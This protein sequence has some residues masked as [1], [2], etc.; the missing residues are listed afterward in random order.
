VILRRF[1]GALGIVLVAATSA[2]AGVSLA[3]ESPAR[4]DLR[5]LNL[6]QSD[7]PGSKIV[8]QGYINYP[9]YVAIFERE[10]EGGGFQQLQ[11]SRS[12]ADVEL[13]KSEVDAKLKMKLLE[14]MFVGAGRQ[15]YIDTFRSQLEAEGYKVVSLSRLRS[16]PLNLGD[17]GIELALK[18]VVT[19]SQAG[20]MKMPFQISSVAFRVHRMLVMLRMDSVPGAT[21]PPGDVTDLANLFAS[22]VTAGLA[23]T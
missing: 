6:R 20:K 10:F 15:A 16:R 5:P 23:T 3:R 4:P 21:L 1:F 2:T 13:A 11:L 7:L 12:L 19:G 18:A 17:G 8:R 22:R 9:G 14:S